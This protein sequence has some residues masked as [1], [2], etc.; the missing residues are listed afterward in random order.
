MKDGNTV[1]AV[2]D[3]THLTIA[4]ARGAYA[5]TYRI[6]NT[7]NNVSIE[8]VTIKNSTTNA[9]EGTDVENVHLGGVVF[10]Y[11]CSRIKDRKLFFYGLG[12]MSV[13]SKY[14]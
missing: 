1:V 14:R 10:S 3:N 5:G 2:A 13:C 8:N 7:I 9:L 6:A 11:Q 12:R 4:S